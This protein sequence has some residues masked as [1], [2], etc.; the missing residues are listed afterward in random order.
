[1]PTEEVLPLNAVP[2][3]SRLN[4]EVAE[5]SSQL[6]GMPGNWRFLANIIRRP[7]R[8]LDLPEPAMVQ[9]L[10]ALQRESLLPIF[11]EKA[12]AGEY[13][14]L[15][16]H[17]LRERLQWAIAAAKASA[18]TLFGELERLV[19]LW[20]EHGLAP[21]L[22]KGSHLALAYYDSP[23][24]RPMSDVDVLFLDLGEAEQAW[25]LAKSAGCSGVIPPMAPDP[26]LFQHELPMLVGQGS[27]LHLEVHG[28]L[29]F[30]P[31]DRRWS[32]LRVLAAEQERTEFADLAAC[33]LK[34]EANL[35][36]LIA[37]NLV[38]HETDGPVLRTCFDVKALLDKMETSF[39]WERATK[40]SRECGFEEEFAKGVLWSVLLAG[41][42][43]PASRLA[44]FKN[45][46]EASSRSPKKP[47]EEIQWTR[48]TMVN[49][50][51]AG[52]PFRMARFAFRLTCPTRSYMR[53]RYP[54]LADKGIVR[55]YLHRWRGQM[56][57]MM[58]ALRAG[59]S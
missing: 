17:S 36:Y 4:S 39:N 45:R 44:Y 43:V 46:L 30:P 56:G 8:V 54:E 20:N 10:D 41:A 22:L 28:S 47:G 26:W 34:P 40:L 59:R 7:E 23:H 37:H 12:L 9:L 15:L 50:F 29:L 32:R 48:G 55:L 19:R 18:A 51:N 52:S 53:F 57:K 2:E 33:G 38:Q 27:G 42:K 24:L 58:R 5:P 1:M 21:C 31:G 3:C 35:V 6:Q 49:I 16:S 11:A 25:A 14:A 13:D